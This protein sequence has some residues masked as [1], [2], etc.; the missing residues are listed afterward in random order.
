MNIWG[1][2]IITDLATTREQPF[3]GNRGS[4]ASKIIDCN[5]VEGGEMVTIV[6]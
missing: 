3:A 4:R 1:S 2:R 6:L 5:M